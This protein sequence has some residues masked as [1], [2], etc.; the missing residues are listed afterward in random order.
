MRSIAA[1]A[2]LSGL[3]LVSAQNPPAPTPSNAVTIEGDASYD[4]PV[5]KGTTGKLGNAAVV[6]N[7]PAGVV[8]K[9]TLPNSK[10]SGVRGSVT[11]SSASQGLSFSVSLSG[12]PS[13]DLGPFSKS[14]IIS[15]VVLFQCSALCL[16]RLLL[17]RSELSLPYPCH[18]SS[19]RWQL[20]CDWTSLGSV[21]SWRNPALRQ[22]CACHLPG[23]RSVGQA[24]E[25][26]QRSFHC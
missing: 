5:I 9:A 13:S 25:H 8:Y 26:H 3:A 24:R 18:A 12:L 17:T 10:T 15:V 16:W 2:A 20:H 19:S 22:H 21:R 1:I 4:G 23:W 7:N 14:S 11:A 6:S